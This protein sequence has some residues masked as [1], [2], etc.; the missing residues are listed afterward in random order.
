MNSRNFQISIFLMILRNFLIFQLFILIRHNLIFS[1]IE[2]LKKIF[3]NQL[4]YFS[5]VASE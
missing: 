5:A 1:F 2:L 3:H 4:I